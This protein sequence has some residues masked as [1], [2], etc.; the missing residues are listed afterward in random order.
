MLLSGHKGASCCVDP[1]FGCTRFGDLRED[2]ASAVADW[3]FAVAIDALAVLFLRLCTGGG[4]AVFSALHVAWFYVAGSLGM[5]ES[6]AP[7]A[8]ANLWGVS[9]V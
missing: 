4:M 6:L 9:F 1:R 7:M 3:V 5:V 8:L 2:R